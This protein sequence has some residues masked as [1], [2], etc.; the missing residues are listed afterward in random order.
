MLKEVRIEECRESEGLS[1]TE[2]IE[3]ETLS[4]VKTGRLLRGLSLRE[5]VRK[6]EKLEAK[7]ICNTFAKYAPDYN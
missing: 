6:L 3:I 1:V 5:T 4:H 7:R 2:R